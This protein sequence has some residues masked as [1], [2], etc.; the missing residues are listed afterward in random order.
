MSCKLSTEGKKNGSR[1]CLMRNLTFLFTQKKIKTNEQ[2]SD[3]MDRLIVY[4]NRIIKCPNYKQN[5][6]S[7]IFLSL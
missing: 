3:N 2:I 6:K 4:K 5:A 7:F 1:M